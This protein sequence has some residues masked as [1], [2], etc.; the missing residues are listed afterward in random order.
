M[1][2]LLDLMYASTI[3]EHLLSVTFRVGLKP[4]A[5]RVARILVKAVIMAALFLEGIA[6]ISMALRL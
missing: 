4:W 5:V 3:F 6:C 2:I 1:S